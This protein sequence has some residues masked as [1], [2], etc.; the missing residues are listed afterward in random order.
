MV[1]RGVLVQLLHRLRGT[2]NAGVGR[3]D[4]AGLRVVWSVDSIQPGVV[5]FLLQGLQGY[6]FII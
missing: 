6:L 1:R 5:A 3:L 4:M 2:A